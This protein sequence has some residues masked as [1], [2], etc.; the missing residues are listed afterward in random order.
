MHCGGKWPPSQTAHCA[1]RFS[2]RRVFRPPDTQIRQIIALRN[3][4]KA[5]AV[6]VIAP[7]P[8]SRIRPVGALPMSLAASVCVGCAPLRQHVARPRLARK[9]MTV[10]AAATPGE[11]LAAPKRSRV[12][13]LMSDYLEAQVGDCRA[14]PPPAPP[15]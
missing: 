13:Y 8:N 2:S 9:G 14:F 3:D 1:C 15:P 11:P 12:L 7:A 10:R 4:C 6:Q 5:F